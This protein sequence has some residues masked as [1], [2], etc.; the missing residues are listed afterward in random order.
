MKTKIIVTI[1][2]LRLILSYSFAQETREFGR[3]VA[4]GQTNLGTSFSDATVILRGWQLQKNNSNGIE[5]MDLGLAITDVEY[6]PASGIVKWNVRM[7]NFSDGDAKDDIRFS[8]DFSVIGLIDGVVKNMLLL[9]PAAPKNGLQSSHEEISV[10]SGYT[11]GMIFPTGFLLHVNPVPI[12]NGGHDYDNE[13]HNFRFELANFFYNSS[14]GKA[15]WDVITDFRDERGSP[16]GYK[17]NYGYTIILTNGGQKFSRSSGFQTSTVSGSISGTFSAASIPQAVVAPLGWE[18]GYASGDHNINIISASISNVSVSGASVS[19]TYNAT[20][21]DKD[22]NPFRWNVVAGGLI[23]G[24]ARIDGHYD[25]P[26]IYRFA[27]MPDNDDL[28]YEARSGS[29]TFI[30]FTANLANGTVA[31]GPLSSDRPFRP[32]TESLP[33]VPPS[34]GTIDAFRVSSAYVISNAE[35]GGIFSGQPYAKWHLWAFP[36]EGFNLDQFKDKLSF[37][38]Q[39]NGILFDLATHA[40]NRR[41]V[42]TLLHGPFQSDTNK[43]EWGEEDDIGPQYL[44]Y[45]NLPIWDWGWGYGDRLVIFLWESDESPLA[46]DDIALLL[47]ERGSTPQETFSTKDINGLPGVLDSFGQQHLG[48]ITFQYA[49]SPG[50][51]FVNYAY[52]GIGKGSWWEPFKTV[53]EGVMA[54]APNNIISVESGSYNEKITI[55]KPLTIRAHGGTVIIGQ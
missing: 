7:V 40:V 9:P 16:Q 35:G 4:T 37:V 24:G 55:T 54:A 20:L 52:T 27:V 28:T 23:F 13:I 43:P 29:G 42:S 44:G 18:L 48:A 3:I 5:I 21:R 1:V 11:V 32:I 34:P 38:G 53:G 19:W 12:T 45:T 10:Q 33:A 39:Y 36:A 8:Y 17:W 30:P 50:D 2:W 14:T 31:A 26:G 22:P 49:R 46:D 25:S 6:Q 51:I 15:S 41:A 47:I